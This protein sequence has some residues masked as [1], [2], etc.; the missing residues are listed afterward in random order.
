MTIDFLCD[1]CNQLMRIGRRKAGTVV[2][3]HNCQNDIIVPK[4]ENGAVDGPEDPR[5]TPANPQAA[6]RGLFEQTDFEKVF[7]QGAAAGPH[8][9]QPPTVAGSPP[10]SPRNPL[11]GPVETG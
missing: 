2:R 1:F 4:V 11:P 6:D 3:C 10:A 5:Q 8:M 9:L 7:G